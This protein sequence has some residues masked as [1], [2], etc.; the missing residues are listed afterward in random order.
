[1]IFHCFQLFLLPHSD[2]PKSSVSRPGGPGWPDASPSGRRGPGGQ[3]GPWRGDPEAGGRPGGD[4]RGRPTPPS[5]SAIKPTSLGAALA[6]TKGAQAAKAA[7]KTGA[8]PS[9]RPIKEP[10]ANQ[11][12]VR[13][14][15]DSGANRG[16]PPV[17][18]PPGRGIPQLGY[19]SFI[20]TPGNLISPPWHHR[21]YYDISIMGEIR[22]YE[23]LKA[24]L[25]T[26]CITIHFSLIG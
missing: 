26:F 8:M 6:Q 2:G 5:S 12:P 22:V 23:F 16:R 7:G 11:G 10:T 21:K 3:G 9:K 1:M 20:I 25:G 14:T 17:R 19:A 15:V 4:K 13:G 24:V 18:A